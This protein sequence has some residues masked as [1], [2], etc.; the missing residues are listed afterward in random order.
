MDTNVDLRFYKTDKMIKDAFL[1]LI[2]TMDF[3][4]I[5]VTN[6][7][8]MAKIS[9]STFYLHYEDKYDLLEQIE[10]EILDGLKKIGANIHLDEIV[11]NGLTHEKPFSLLLQIY[12][13]VKKNQQFFKAILCNNGDPYFYYKL[14]KSI[15]FVYEQNIDEKRFKIP[16]NYAI[17]FVIAVQTSII[18][19][20]I[21]SGMK[22]SPEEMVS[23]ITQLMNNVPKN[24]YR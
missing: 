18:S 3:E 13:Y 7:T 2:N 21:K 14:N 24:M 9:R 12:E 23:M 19:E 6:I 15:K 4:K 22:E 17:A 16:K 5:S 1:E 10:D 8:Q 11:E 20:W